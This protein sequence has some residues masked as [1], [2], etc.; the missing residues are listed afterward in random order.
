[1]R[2]CTTGRKLK[3]K[4]KSKRRRQR[5]QADKRLDATTAFGILHRAGR[6]EDFQ[7]EVF[8]SLMRWSLREMSKIEEEEQTPQETKR[9][10]RS[11]KRRREEFEW[12]HE[13]SMQGSGIIEV[14]N[15]S[16]NPIIVKVGGACVARHERRTRSAPD[17]IEFIDWFGERCFLRFGLSAA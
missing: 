16:R 8:E 2:R 4:L 1:M 9:T 10:R 11:T 7:K 12:D 6:L 3:S 15:K 14:H 13:V 5:R 17:R